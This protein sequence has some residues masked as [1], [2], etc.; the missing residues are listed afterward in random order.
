MRSRLLGLGL[1]LLAVLLLAVDYT[2]AL[3]TA[4]GLE[5]DRLA[6]PIGATGPTIERARE[7]TDGLLDTISFASIALIGAA[8]AGVALLRRRPRQA[9]AAAATIAGANVTTQVLKPLLGRL[10]P[11]GGDVDRISQGIFPSGHATVAMSVA[12]AL[13]IVVPTQVRPL[14]AVAAGAYSGAVGVGLVLL[15]WHF[16]SD[17]VG[18]FLVATAW[19]AGAIAVVGQGRRE[20]RRGAPSAGGV[21]AGAA[22][23]A[24]V[25]L[26]AVAAGVAIGV[27][28][29]DPGQIVEIGRVHT[30][31]LLGAATIA[32]FAASLPAGM[33]ALMMQGR[34]GD[35]SRRGQP[36]S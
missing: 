26:G 18:G 14:A 25:A 23:A 30:A 35:R 12:L 5:A 22:A 28:A 8:A 10:D 7:A 13:V 36:L 9:L 33:A 29:G 1:A 32:A 34:A 6:L 16:P 3:G 4:A 21:R 24:A 17:V 20:A 27:R 19:A 31:F 2:L 11:L 15:G